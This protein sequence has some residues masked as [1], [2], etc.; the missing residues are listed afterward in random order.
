MVGG[1]ESLTWYRGLPLWQLDADFH[2]AASE[3]RALGIALDIDDSLRVWGRAVEA[4]REVESAA[5][6]LHGD[7]LTE[8]LLVDGSGGLAA[9]LDFGGAGDR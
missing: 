2:A 4:S 6:W 8:N 7:L 1:D 5:A 9:V 3:C